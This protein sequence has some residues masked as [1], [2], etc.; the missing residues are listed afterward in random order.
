MKLKIIILLQLSVTDGLN[1]SSSSIT[2]NISDVN[3][4]PVWN[5]ALQTVFNYPENSTAV[6]TIDIPEDIADEDGDALSYSLSGTDASLFS[7]SGNAVSFVGAPDY[8]NPSD[9]NGD[10]IYN[11]N[12]IASDGELSATSP[13]FSL[14]N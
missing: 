3:E 7:I 12:V 14:H 10:N 5:N 8:E 13:E 2:V 11:L 9:S 6:E 1:S 4:P